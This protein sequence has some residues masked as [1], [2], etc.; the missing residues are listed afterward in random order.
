MFFLVLLM[1]EEEGRKEKDAREEATGPRLMPED[2][3]PTGL[4]V[5]RALEVRIVGCRPSYRLGGPWRC[6]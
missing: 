3:V 6:E 2:R 1:A 5:W 4:Q